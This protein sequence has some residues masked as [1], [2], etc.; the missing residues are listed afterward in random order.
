MIVTF[1]P[2]PRK[3]PS[4]HPAHDSAA[5]GA[6]QIKGNRQKEAAPVRRGD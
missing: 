5:R 4:H 1:G 3:V 6:R 2:D